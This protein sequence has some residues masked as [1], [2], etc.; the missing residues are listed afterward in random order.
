ML[1]L[2]TLVLP[3]YALPGTA[4][5]KS[6]VHDVHDGYEN[7]YLIALQRETPKEAVEGIAIALAAGYGLELG[8]TWRSLKSFR[9]LGPKDLVEQ[10]ASDPRV[11][12]AEQNHRG[13]LTGAFSGEYS[14]NFNGDYRWAIDRLDEATYDE[15]DSKYHMCH[16]GKNVTIY[17]MDTGIDYDHVEFAGRMHTNVYNFTTTDVNSD[18]H[19]QCDGSAQAWHGTAVA[20]LA[21]GANVGSSRANMVSLKVA[22]CNTLAVDV[23]AFSDAL[24]WMAGYTD[25]T[26]T[27][28]QGTT[29]YSNT[30]GYG[31]VVFSGY[32]PDWGNNYTFINNAVAAFVYDT[33]FAFFTSADNF[34]SDSCK[35]APNARAFTASNT[36]GQVF[37]AAASAI[38]GEANDITDYEL[39]NWEV[40]L[41]PEFGTNLGNCI[42]AF[43]PGGSVY[44]ARHN[45]YGSLYDI[46]SGTSFSAPL[47][48]G[49]GARYAEYYRSIYFAYPSP[50]TL[51][52]WLRT[53]GS[54]VPDD[55]G[56]IGTTYK[57]CHVTYSNG[58]EELHGTTSGSCDVFVGGST[59]PYNGT[60]VT[61]LDDMPAST[62]TQSATIAYWDEGTCSQCKSSLS[63]FRRL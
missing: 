31:I 21:G 15:G 4:E 46:A 5:P 17:I 2:I 7:D 62:N 20:S 38:S 16:E 51:Y 45:K 28:D 44:S 53:Q 61:Y 41:G 59:H 47:A 60:S 12:F 13:R 1:A 22:G 55:D 29:T 35:F 58:G 18:Q 37:V 6:R 48:A 3:S 24:D 50:Q 8:Q 19:D 25:L 52:S 57:L 14:A 49:L 23:D 30:H 36:S 33:G 54:T 26:E 11:L 27:T 42:S 10:L 40:P 63:L 39:R 43:A 9:V 56:Y 34:A 32:F